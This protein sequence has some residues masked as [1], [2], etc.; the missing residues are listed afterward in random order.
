MEFDDTVMAWDHR[1]CF[2]C[3]DENLP[4][5]TQAGMFT[6]EVMYFRLGLVRFAH[7]L[8]HFQMYHVGF[9][10]K[11]ECKSTKRS[12]PLPWV[13]LWTSLGLN[14]VEKICWDNVEVLHVIAF[15]LHVKPK[16]Q[17]VEILVVLGLKCISYNQDVH[18]KWPRTFFFLVHKI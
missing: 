16:G 18:L 3:A 11:L 2:H 8:P 12:A 14:I 13:I 5:V 6:D 1:T 9:T 4:D 7:F 17:P 15:T 10:R